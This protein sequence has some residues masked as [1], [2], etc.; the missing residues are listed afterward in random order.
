MAGLIKFFTTLGSKEAQ[1]A[2]RSI[3]DILVRWD[4]ETA[5]EAELAI[6]EKSLDKV[7][8]EV[9]RAKSVS[10]KEQAEAVAIRKAHAEKV[11]AGEVLEKELK[12]AKGKEKKEIEDA[13]TSLVEDLEELNPEVE[14][15]S[16][17][18]KEA[19]IYF[20]ELEGIATSSAEKLKTAKKR[21]ESARR[22][23]KTAEVRKQ[24]SEEKAEQSARIAGLRENSETIGSAL[25]SMQRAADTANEEAAASELKAKLLTPSSSNDR[26]ADAL[27]QV[28]GEENTSSTK[29][30]LTRF[31]ELKKKS[32]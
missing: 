14:R 2:G 30:A 20:K 15:E 12:T 5:S 11:A 27:A 9:A 7:T 13:L 22:G 19:Q 31:K 32:G 23:L 10:E 16:Q 26:V 24:R 18:A 29:D 4:P 3:T 28:R 1:K 17:E 6:M 25:S 21:L 8:R